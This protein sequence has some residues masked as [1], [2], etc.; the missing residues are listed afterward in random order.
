M[1]ILSQT[2]PSTDEEHKKQNM[3][4]IEANDPSA[5]CKA[6]LEQYSKGN[7]RKAF[8]NYTKSAEL[9]E[10]E[11][12]Y[13]LAHL[14]HDGLGVEKNVGK[15]IY[16]LEEA[17]IG[18]HPTA[19]HNLGAIEW[20]NNRNLDRAVKHWIIAATL[21][22]DDSTKLLMDTFKDGNISKEILTATLHA[23]QTAVNATKSPQRSEADIYFR[24]NKR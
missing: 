17:A 16:H 11:A 19:R 8:H 7:Y 1:S 14:Y 18:G 12:H 9:G 24:E 20:N 2:L 13:Q 10:A 15:E 3:K 21:G 22:F 23:Y 5:M 6:G 4:R